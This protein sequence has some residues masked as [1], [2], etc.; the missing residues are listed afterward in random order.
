[1]SIF[2]VIFPSLRFPLPCLPSLEWT[3]AQTSSSGS[4]GVLVVEEGVV[5]HSSKA[6]FLHAPH[7][8]AMPDVVNPQFRTLEPAAMRSR[9][10]AP[11]ANGRTSSSSSRLRS[12]F[13]ISSGV[14]VRSPTVPRGANTCAHPCAVTIATHA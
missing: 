12:A 8:A 14:F 11:I 7:H 1:M 9:S 3:S 13:A 4:Y 2:L 5:L 6:L 10:R